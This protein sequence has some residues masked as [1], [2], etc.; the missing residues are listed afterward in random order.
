MSVGGRVESRVREWKVD[1]REASCR[2]ELG[3]SQRQGVATAQKQK[4]CTFVQVSEVV[5][6]M[7]F[8]PMISRMR[9]LRPGPARRTERC[10]FLT[11]QI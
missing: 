1:G 2:A 5:L 4:T 7:G 10:S 8:E 11:M 9:I 6:G 3:C